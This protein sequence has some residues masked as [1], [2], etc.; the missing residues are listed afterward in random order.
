MDLM[1][2]EWGYMLGSRNG[3]G[4]TFWEGYLEN[5]SFDY[6][7]P[8]MSLAHGWATGPTSALTQYAA[9]VGPELSSS[10]PFHFI[11]HMGTLTRS[12][13]TVSLPQG[14]V[15]V[16]WESTGGRFN[17]HVAA[18][19]TMAGR[20]GV[21][22]G[23]S[24]ASVFVDGAMVWSSCS[25]IAAQGVGAVTHEGGYVYLSQVAGSHEVISTDRCSSQ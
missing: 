10:V 4:S 16:S 13:A 17:G 1:R 6:G 20:Y 5:G 11:P 23:G 12:S 25:A 22:V 24:S 7:G 2:L 3:T 15:S 21:P 9:G 14:R 18:P 8:V 19:A